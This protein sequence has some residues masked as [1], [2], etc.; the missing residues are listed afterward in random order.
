MSSVTVSR[1]TIAAISFVCLLSSP[2]IGGTHARPES[3][4][5][6]AVSG[7]VSEVE[8]EFHITKNAQGEDVLKLVDTSYV[9]I[10]GTGQKI[11]LKL[12]RETKVPARANPGDRI[13]A[14][15]SKEGETLSVI[16]IE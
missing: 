11:H 4:T 15:I 2:K 13:E 8:G 16:R 7:H 10:T 6:K 5:S 1:V 3:S 12:T 9:I 14:K